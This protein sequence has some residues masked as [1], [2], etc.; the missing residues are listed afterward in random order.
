MTVDDFPYDLVVISFH[1]VS[2]SGKFISRRPLQILIRN[3]STW[4]YPLW[5]SLTFGIEAH[6]SDSVWTYTL[7]LKRFRKVTRVV[8]RCLDLRIITCL[9]SSIPRERRWLSGDY[10]W[11]SL[12]RVVDIW[13]YLRRE[14]QSNGIYTD[15][16]PRGH[17]RNGDRLSIF[18]GRTSWRQVGHPESY[19]VSISVLLRSFYIL[20]PFDNWRASLWNRLIKSTKRPS[21]GSM[22][23][24]SSQSYVSAREKKL[25]IDIRNGKCKI[26]RTREDESFG[27]STFV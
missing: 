15:G 11:R 9:A 4:E 3:A 19:W 27:T 12:T 24:P 8:V 1:G 5:M 18:R 13:G 10:C 2:S 16:R 22:G 23:I 25:G 14:H 20:I 17:T 21:K 26:W 7:Y 6:Q